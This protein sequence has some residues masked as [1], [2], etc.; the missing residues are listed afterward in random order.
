MVPFLALL[1]V[2]V[3]APAVHAEETFP[4]PPPSP[5][6]EVYGSF[7]PNGDTEVSV[8]Y[9]TPSRTPEFVRVVKSRTC[10][11]GEVAVVIVMQS[12]NRR[13]EGFGLCLLHATHGDLLQVTSPSGATFF[14]NFGLR[15]VAIGVNRGRGGV[16]L[17]EFSF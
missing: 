8:A 4:F 12:H 2:I 5:I 1:Y 10:S 7:S 9:T 16:H 11:E 14:R 3:V 13:I 15:L 6:E 17:L